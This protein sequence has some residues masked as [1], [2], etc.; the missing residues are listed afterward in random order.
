MKTITV[1]PRCG[2]ADVLQDA[3]V[4]VND[5]DN[6]S[7]FDQLL[8]GNDECGYDGSQF[9]QVEVADDFDIYEDFYKEPTP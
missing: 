7:T 9:K 4:R 5:P 2:C 3:Y 6:V 1:C 8:C